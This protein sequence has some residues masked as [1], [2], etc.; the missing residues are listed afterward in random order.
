MSTV[1]FDK[2]LLKEA[3]RHSVGMV[4]VAA[5]LLALASLSLLVTSWFASSTSIFVGQILFVVFVFSAVTVLVI[6]A[7]AQD[8]RKRRAFGDRREKHGV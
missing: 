2:D 8:I 4:I 6:T 1:T 5:G 7:I 3:K